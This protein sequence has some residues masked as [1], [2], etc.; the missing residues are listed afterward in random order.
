[1]TT[2]IPEPGSHTSFQVKFRPLQYLKGPRDKTGRWRVRWWVGHSK[3]EGH[4]SFPLKVPAE[5]FLNQL[6]TALDNGEPFD[7]ITHLPASM[8]R[9]RQTVT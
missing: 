3:N 9:A 7:M 8:A 1:M 4:E 5:R 2:P 6:K